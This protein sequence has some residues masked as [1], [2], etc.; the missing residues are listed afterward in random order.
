M[1][2]AS[3]ADAAARPP[4]LRSLNHELRTPLATIQTFADLMDDGALGP[5]TEEQQD[6]IQAILRAVEKIENVSVGLSREIDR[7]GT[8]R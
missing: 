3:T 6:A 2:S 5:I 8:V 1:F 4:S 7:L